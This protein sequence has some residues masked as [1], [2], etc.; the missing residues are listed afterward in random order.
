[1]VYHVERQRD[2]ASSK[3]GE[4]AKVRACPERAERVEREASL[5]ISDSS[6]LNSW[7]PN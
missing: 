1:M 4:A 5:D 3:G 6:F 2:V 7:F